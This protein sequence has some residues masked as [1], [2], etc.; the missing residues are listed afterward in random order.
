MQIGVSHTKIQGL[1]T[2]YSVFWIRFHYH[3]RSMKI[4][5]EYLMYS[6][7]WWQCASTDSLVNKVPRYVTSE[8]VAHQSDLNLAEV[9]G[10]CGQELLQLVQDCGHA[11][12]GGRRR[13]VRVAKS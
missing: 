10:Q 4:R 12:Q 3:H 8:A 9:R 5:I 6:H 13:L 2:S 7:L 11:V 1:V